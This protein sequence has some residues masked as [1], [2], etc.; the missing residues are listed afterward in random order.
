MFCGLTFFAYLD[1]EVRDELI[2]ALNAGKT[3]PG[4]STATVAKQSGKIPELGN[5]HS[6]KK[7]K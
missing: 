5:I 6:L 2:T 3:H 1:L 4:W 7:I